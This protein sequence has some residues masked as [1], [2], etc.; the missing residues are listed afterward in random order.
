LVDLVQRGLEENTKGGKEE[1]VS[2]LT[3]TT[4]GLPSLASAQM[5]VKIQLHRQAILHNT[6]ICYCIYHFISYYNL[7]LQNCMWLSGTLLSMHDVYNT[8]H[9]HQ[10]EWAK[11][12]R[13]AS[14]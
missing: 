11:W 7:L 1:A 2:V 3:H 14:P 6:V 10:D 9:L 13:P 8:K 12:M 4:K 5:E